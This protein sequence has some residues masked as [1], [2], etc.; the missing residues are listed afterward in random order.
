MTFNEEHALETYKSLIGFGTQ[1]LRGLQ[2]LNGGAVVAI[3]AYMGQAAGTVDTTKIRCSLLV[4]IVGL[5]LTALASLIAYLT[6]FSLFNE[7]VNPHYEGKRHTFWLWIAIFLL[8][9]SL[10][11]FIT[12]SYL[13]VIALAG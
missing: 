10:A 7:L 1:A 12:G 5:S 8:F 2:L 3:L 6:Q 9:S 13:G 4:F 11:C